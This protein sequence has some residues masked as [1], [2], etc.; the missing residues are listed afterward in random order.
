M[1]KKILLSKLIR[2]QDELKKLRLASFPLQ[3][4]NPVIELNVA[5]NIDFAN[6]AALEKARELGLK[7]VLGF[8]PK[9]IKKIIKH[10][11]GK[12]SKETYHEVSVKNTTFGENIHW[13]PQFNAA[14]VF[15]TDITSRKRTEEKLKKINDDINE[16][17]D[18]KV[19]EKTGELVRANRAL[20][21][22]SA[23]NK[24]LIYSQSEEELFNEICRTIIAVGQYRWAWVG[25]VE[26]DEQKNVKAVAQMGLE[27]GY[28]ESANITWSDKDPRGRG[29]IGLAIRMGKI[30]VGKNFSKDANLAPWKSEAVKRGFGS[31][32]ALP[33]KNQEEA[34]GVLAIYAKEP[35]AFHK[36]EIKLLYE[37]SENLAF[38]I[39]TLREKK[40][41]AE[42][43]ELILTSNELLRLSN[44]ATSHQNYLDSAVQYIKKW[45]GCAF[46]GVRILQKEEFIPHESYTGF[47]HDFW[48]S[49]NMLSL[50]K[51]QCACI[52]V[53]AGKPDLQDRSAMTKTGSFYTNDS[54]EFIA[55]LS[56]KEQ[57]RFRGKCIRCGF[58]SIA[59]IP[60][61]RQETILGAIHIADNKQGMLPLKKIETLESLAVLIGEAISKFN[62]QARLIESYKHL[63]TINR[64]IPLLLELDKHGKHG[65][66]KE[67]SQYILNSAVNISQAKAGFLY[68]LEEGEEFYLLASSGIS[69]REKKDFK[70]I[71]NKEY[72]ILKKILNEKG[73]ASEISGGPAFSRLNLNGNLKCFVVLPLKKRRDNKLKGFLLLGFTNVQCMDSQELEFYDVFSMHASAAL[74]GAEVFK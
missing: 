30:I 21:V 58:D 9:D 18:E 24:A 39:N 8:L 19:Q 72:K 68:R 42:A 29:P 17:L 5:G 65:R 50:K 23:C 43:E 44:H 11:A 3:N 22:L 13:A 45:S 7:N 20:A 28:L 57:L 66:K 6:P 40:H 51:D 70:A 12:K 71:R 27:K 14:H 54:A 62:A 26:Q 61:R 36:N 55:G 46:V 64:K 25:K 49:E 15:M 16:K 4:P 53:I 47:S 31:I 2:G 74:L 56:A 48:Q 38:G 37:L 35:A 33:L 63:G 41:H 34:F 67:I 69:D 59:I 52:R 1:G 60:I 73:K 32:I 10:L